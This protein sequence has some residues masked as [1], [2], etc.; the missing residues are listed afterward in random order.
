VILQLRL[1]SIQ[2]FVDFRHGLFHG[3]I[4]GYALFLTHAGQFC[5]T[6]RTDLCNLLRRTDTGHYVFALRIDEVLTVEEVFARSSIAAEAY[7][8]G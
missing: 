7:A 6:L 3:R 4:L 8:R 5:P 2:F 1:Q